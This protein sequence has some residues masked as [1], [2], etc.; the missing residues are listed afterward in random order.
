MNVLYGLHTSL[1]LPAFLEQS[2]V[3]DYHRRVGTIIGET[4]QFFAGHGRH[5]KPD[6]KVAHNRGS[7]NLSHTADTSGKR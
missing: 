6:F 1:H 3:E 5:F 7:P 4:V 2:V